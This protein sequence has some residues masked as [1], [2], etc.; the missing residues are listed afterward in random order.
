MSLDYFIRKVENIHRNLSGG[1]STAL[2]G[3]KDKFILLKC[4]LETSMDIL[5]RLQDE[6]ASLAHRSE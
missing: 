5:Q 4:E 1:E 2:I 3:S 6:K